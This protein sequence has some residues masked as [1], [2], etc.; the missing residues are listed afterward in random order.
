MS[1]QVGKRQG[2]PEQ[3]KKVNDN[4]AQISFLKSENV[5]WKVKLRN[6]EE[7]YNHEK[8]KLERA[9]FVLMQ[10]RESL[11]LVEEEI[12]SDP[13]PEGAQPKERLQKRDYFRMVIFICIFSCNA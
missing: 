3:R 7:E 11:S 9:N 13:L 1:H 4:L 12:D 2:D 5:Q 6:Q 8:K 10:A